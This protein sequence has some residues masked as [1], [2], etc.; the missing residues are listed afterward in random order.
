MPKTPDYFHDKAILITRAGSGIGRAAALVFA[1]EGAG[2]V[3]SDIDEPAAERVANQVLET[4]AIHERTKRGRGDARI[5]G[6]FRGRS[7]GSMNNPG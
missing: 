1:R 6:P 3:C 7:R 5:F 2:V 4:W